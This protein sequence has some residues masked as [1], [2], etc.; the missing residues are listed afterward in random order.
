V[1]ITLHC[2][3][4]VLVLA[5]AIALASSPALA[6]SSA[7]PGWPERSVRAIVPNPP[8][9]ALDISLRLFSERLSA[10]W[11]QPVVVENMPGAD[12]IIAAREFVTRRD[13]HTLLYSFA[14]L[15]SI[16]PL[17]HE[18]LP[19]DVADLAPIVA[20]TDNFIAIA[21]PAAS[22][23]N[24]LAEL[25]ALARS[26][27][28]KLT[29]AATPGLP[30]YA[31]AAF[32]KSTGVGMVQAS[33]R[34]FNPAIVDLGEGRIDAL[35]SGV[36]PLLPQARAGKIKLLAFVNRERSPAAPEVP[37]VAEAGYP[38]LT[39]SAV[40][41]FFGG[42]DMPAALRERIAA[43]VRAV[44]AE[45]AIKER[46]GKMGAVALAGTPAAFAAAIEE[47]RAKVAAIAKAMGT[48]AGN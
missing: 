6:Q 46:L 32:Q 10:R 21:V 28:G 47:Q 39:F 33:Y 41:G 19:Y 16:N 5:V 24:S 37:T 4:F 29:F 8:G 35:A 20:T 34:D 1:R 26:R 44:A 30:F 3:S 12:G 43:D 27:P 14:G 2:R 11:K 13:S 48:K 31:L 38:Q 36:A 9:V 17:L 15:I 25:E 22:K 45:A 42:R 18:K 40:T 23:V 7:A